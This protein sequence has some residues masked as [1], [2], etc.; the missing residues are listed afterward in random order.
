[1]AQ[2][3]G[4]GSAGDRT[5]D[6]ELRALTFDNAP[7]LAELFRQRD[8]WRN[9]GYESEP[10]SFLLRLRL[11]QGDMTGLLF[12]RTS[13]DRAIGFVLGFGRVGPQAALEFAIAVPDPGERRRSIGKTLGMRAVSWF[14]EHELCEKLWAWGD[15]K[16]TAMLALVRA[17]D[18]EV[19]GFEE[20]GR[21]MVDGPTETVEVRMTRE[22]WLAWRARQ[23][24]DH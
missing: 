22:R 9:F 21:Q 17:C 13:T 19:V 11:R 16:N 18:W 14:F 15:A 5:D 8:V 10:S 1:M 20:G 7:V 2:Q 12:H 3:E 23:A 24:A 4:S 6:I